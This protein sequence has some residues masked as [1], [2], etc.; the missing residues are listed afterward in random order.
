MINKENLTHHPIHSQANKVLIIVPAYNEEEGISNVVSDIRLRLP[1]ADVIVINDGSSDNTGR[2]AEETGA[3]VIHLPVNLG[4]GGAVQT[5]YRFA[6]AHGYKYAAQ[7]DGDGQHN[8]MD[9][10]KMLEV[11]LTTDADMVIGSRF[12]ENKGFQSTFTRKIG[13]EMLARLVSSLI[14]RRVTDPT[15]GYR[16]CGPRAIALFAREYPSDYPEVEALVLLDNTNCSFVE[17]PVVM[18]A[19]LSGISS[20]SAFNSVYYMVKV[21]L[22]VIIAKSRKKKTWRLLHES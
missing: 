18:N 5:G 16:A 21:I 19:R 2:V 12:L 9:F 17:I 13:I 1:Y 20:I 8:P 15:S 10:G 11:L 14:G 4:I 3:K 6:E 7:I 22:A